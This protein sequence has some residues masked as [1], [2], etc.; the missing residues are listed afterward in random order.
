MEYVIAAVVAVGVLLLMTIAFKSI[1][2][3]ELPK[4]AEAKEAP[5]KPQVSQK[6]KKKLAAQ[7]REEAREQEEMEAILA[8]EISRN[9][10]MSTDSKSMQPEVLEAVPK[11]VGKGSQKAGSTQKRKE[12]VVERQ[13]NRASDDGFKPVP[14]A[15]R[16][17]KKEKPRAS[18]PSDF[19]IDEEMEKKLADFFRR[20]D[21]RSKG[22]SGVSATQEPEAKGNYVRV[23]EDFSINSTW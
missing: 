16:A 7:Q 1:S 2:G 11:K 3:G 13:D 10:G 15:S 22:F 20:S 8:R 6:M 21:R 17:P 4:V 9:P 12:A 14:V 23:T 19:E 18:A 5:R